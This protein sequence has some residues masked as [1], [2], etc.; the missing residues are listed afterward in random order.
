M[1]RALL[2]KSKILIMDESTSNIDS[3][4]D[5]S[6]QQMLKDEFKDC[7]VISIAHRLDTILWYDKVLVL[8]QGQ[9][10]EYDSPNT[11]AQD[12]NS[13]FYSLLQEFKQEINKKTLFFFFFFFFFK[14]YFQLLNVIQQMR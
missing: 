6:I 1:A 2:A 7:V 4:T 9:I 11:L 8:D 14:S 10:V 13:E 3:K 5:A 12:S